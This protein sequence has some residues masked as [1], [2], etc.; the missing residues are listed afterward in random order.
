[1]SVQNFMAINLPAVEIFQSGQKVVDQLTNT[2][3][4][5]PNV[6]GMDLYGHK[7][8]LIYNVAPNVLMQPEINI[9]G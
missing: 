1:M 3:I 9:S 4:H 2:A 6:Y 7:A 8:F 5:R